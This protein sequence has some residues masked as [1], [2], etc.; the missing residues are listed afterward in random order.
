M[1]QL[2]SV[3]MAALRLG[4]KPITV[5]AWIAQRRIAVVRL[6][7]RVLVPESEVTRLIKGNLV[8]ALPELAS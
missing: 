5:R 3:E 2:L 7:R 4:L 1:D 6:G 8:P